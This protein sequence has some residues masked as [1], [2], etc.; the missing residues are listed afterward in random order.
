MAKF[1]LVGARNQCAFWRST[2]SSRQDFRTNEWVDFASKE[3]ALLSTM[4]LDVVKSSEIEGEMLIYEQ[5][6]SSIA[7]QLG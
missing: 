3:E 5:V 6:R 1:Y 4:T 2:S 7:R